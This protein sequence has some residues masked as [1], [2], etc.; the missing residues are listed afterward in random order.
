[1]VEQRNLK[2]MRN[3]QEVPPQ[4]Y[5]EI[6]EEEKRDKYYQKNRAISFLF[7]II[8]IVIL[9]FCKKSIPERVCPPTY[10]FD[11]SSA[12]CYPCQHSKCIECSYKYDACSTCQRGFHPN[13]RE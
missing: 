13:V 4:Y 2:E 3:K 6:S 9:I 7:M 11:S 1:M 5:V 12:V 10:G 8:F